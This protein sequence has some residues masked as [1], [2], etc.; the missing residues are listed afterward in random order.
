MKMQYSPSNSREPLLSAQAQLS[1]TPTSV[2]AAKRIRS[3]VS[4]SSHARFAASAYRQMPRMPP[5]AEEE[6]E[7]PM[8]APSVV[9]MLECL[10]A[11]PS[12]SQ[13]NP[14]THPRA[15]RK[16]LQVPPHMRCALTSQLLA[17]PVILEN[18]YS[19]E[20]EPLRGWLQTPRCLGGDLLCTAAAS[21]IFAALCSVSVLACFAS[22]MPVAPAAYGAVAGSSAAGAC[23]AGAMG[24]AYYTESH[25]RAEEAWRGGLHTFID[26]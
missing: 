18:T 1:S 6:L 25:D 15:M 8:T 12:A 23:L 22:C 26:F 4:R 11:A 3:G 17:D 16:A 2:E 21:G 10:D 5:I 9:S 24:H 20:Y 14:R 7:N 19:H 13:I